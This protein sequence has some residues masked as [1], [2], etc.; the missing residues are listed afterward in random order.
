MKK[1]LIISI[2]TILLAGCSGGGGVQAPSENQAANPGYVLGNET[3]KVKIVEFSDYECP[4]CGRFHEGAFPDLKTNYI[5][6]GLVSF[7]FKDFPLPIHPNARSASQATYC[8]G[9][10]AGE[11]AF[12]DMSAK[13]FA[14]QDSLSKNNILKYAEEFE[15]DQEALS[16]CIDERR[17]FDVINANMQEGINSGVSGTP[18][19]FINDVLVTGAQSFEVYKE[20]IDEM[21][22]S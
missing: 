5:D 9:E 15:V 4:F 13:L 17:Y 22:A 16:Q 7:E 12:W 19:V 14:N 1:L 10:Q 20:I 2:F 8:V 3:A 11:D 6:T 18:S 21:L